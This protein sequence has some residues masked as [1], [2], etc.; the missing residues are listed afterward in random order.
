MIFQLRSLRNRREIG[1]NTSSEI[2]QW[3]Q[4]HLQDGSRVTIFNN[5]SFPERPLFL[6]P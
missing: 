3:K 6:F 2:T 1:V 5:I 4:L